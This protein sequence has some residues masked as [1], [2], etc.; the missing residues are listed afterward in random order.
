MR[1]A[2]MSDVLRVGLLV[3]I[4]LMASACGG[5]GGEAKARTVPDYGE[6]RAG[7]YATDEFKPAFSF[8]IVGKGWEIT[9]PELRDV[10]DMTQ[11]SSVLAFFN[12]EKVFD[13]S[14]PRELVSVSAPEDMVAWLQRHP[15][16]GV[17]KPEPATIGG[18]QG[19]QLDAVVA[20]A[21]TSVCGPTCLG[22]FR[23]SNGTEWVVYE[24]EKLRFIVLEDVGG[25]TVTIVVEAPAMEFEE[26]VPKVQKVL[27]TREGRSIMLRP[28]R[29]SKVVCPL[30][31]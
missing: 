27:V 19:V 21:P 17:E 7:E 4:V 9:G 2:V 20:S 29:A 8:K 10:L 22:L 12:A 14:K 13:P 16:L 30:A 28:S 6:L 5:G 26:F 24:E 11:G 18:V 15:Y 3:F 25:Q 31:I 1:R 23:E